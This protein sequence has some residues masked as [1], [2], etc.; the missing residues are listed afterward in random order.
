M[1]EPAAPDTNDGS[2]DIRASSQRSVEVVNVL[3]H[4]GAEQYRFAK[5]TIRCEPIQQVEK[6]VLHAP[7]I[8][9]GAGLCISLGML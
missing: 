4:L 2:L 3:N 1:N 8:H 5:H 7:Y 6:N 9:R